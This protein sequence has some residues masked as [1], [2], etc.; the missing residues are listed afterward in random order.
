[1][2]FSNYQ[3]YIPK[4]LITIISLPKFCQNHSKEWV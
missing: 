3:L 4:E 1:M 2:L